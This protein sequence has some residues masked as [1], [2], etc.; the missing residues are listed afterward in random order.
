MS[1]REQKKWGVYHAIKQRH[2]TRFWGWDWYLG[3]LVVA[4]YDSKRTT[5][6]TNRCLARTVY[7]L[8]GVR[9]YNLPGRPGN[10]Q[11]YGTIVERALDGMSAM[12]SF[13]VQR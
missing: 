2:E 13:G 12:Y 9:V 10:Y 6:I 3:A 8:P 11:W 4:E 5:F 7:A 1:R